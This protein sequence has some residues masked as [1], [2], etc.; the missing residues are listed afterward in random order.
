MTGEK[1]SAS[2]FKKLE[3]A[4]DI[5]LNGFR[6]EASDGIAG[7]IEQVLYWSDAKVPDY[8]VIDSGRWLFGHKSILSIGMIDD[9]DMENRS[10]RIRLSKREIREAPE[11]LPC[12]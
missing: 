7:R 6:V 4:G 3:S 2:W 5:D 11:F 8:V 1:V 10:L 12:T 9:V